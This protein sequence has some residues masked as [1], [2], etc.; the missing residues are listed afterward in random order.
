[1]WLR[2][3]RVAVFSVATAVGGLAL[4]DAAGG[5]LRAS[6]QPELPTAF[7]SRPVSDFTVEGLLFP[8][9]HPAAASRAT[10]P[11]TDGWFRARATVS[12]G[13]MVQAADDGQPAPLWQDRDVLAV[14]PTAFG[15]GARITGAL[16]LVRAA[17]YVVHVRAASRDG[18]V[19][20]MTP[21]D[22][23]AALLV[24]PH[25]GDEPVVVEA[26]DGDGRQVSSVPVRLGERPS[27]TP[28]CLSEA[29]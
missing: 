13:W 5:A 25:K 9:L 19:D 28:R 1:M 20:S 26:F 12:N 22:G 7:F 3:A 24:Q 18:V 15:E 16:I 8:S 14:A 10:C 11:G 17:P 4:G 21:T 6:V 29:L 27:G 2:L 23:W